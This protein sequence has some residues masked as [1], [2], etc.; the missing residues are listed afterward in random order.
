MPDIMFM[1]SFIYFKN[2]K[3]KDAEKKAIQTYFAEPLTFDIFFER[4]ITQ[5]EES[6]LDFSSF[7]DFFSDLKKQNNLTEFQN[8]LTEFEKSETYNKY[9]SKYHE[10]KSQLRKNTDERTSDD[11]LDKLLELERLEKY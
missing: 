9:K 4:P 6:N 2:N 5:N 11:L 7:K 8:W 3:I 1:A 10:L